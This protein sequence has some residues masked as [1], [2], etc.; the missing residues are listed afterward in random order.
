MFSTRKS[1]VAVAVTFYNKDTGERAVIKITGVDDLDTLLPRLRSNGW[2]PERGTAITRA[3]AKR[4][5]G[6]A[7]SSAFLRI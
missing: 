5:H 1:D 7:T 2:V 4:E 3:D 6:W